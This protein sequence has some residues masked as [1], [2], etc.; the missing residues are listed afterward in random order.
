MNFLQDC[1]E[2]DKGFMPMKKNTRKV[3]KSLFAECNRVQQQ[4]YYSIAR[5]SELFQRIMLRAPHVN[6]NNMKSHQKYSVRMNHRWTSLQ[7]NDLAKD[8][9]WEG[10]KRQPFQKRIQWKNCLSKPSKLQAGIAS[11]SK[12]MNSN[13]FLVERTHSSYFIKFHWNRFHFTRIIPV[14][15]WKFTKRKQQGAIE[16]IDFP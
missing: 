12:A 14:K 9:G 3:S 13:E 1:S 4:Q 2:F 11:G 16:I 7:P 8:W 15:R 10:L 5:Y 6:M